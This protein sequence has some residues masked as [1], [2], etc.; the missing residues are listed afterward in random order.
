MAQPPVVIAGAVP[1]AVTAAG[2]VYNR[3]T[4]VQGRTGNQPPLQT[5]AVSPMTVER[6]QPPTT[7]PAARY[8][9]TLNDATWGTVAPG[10]VPHVKVDP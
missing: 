1:L 3:P 4:N 8:Y 6:V 2:P 9:S 10:G 7:D 5:L